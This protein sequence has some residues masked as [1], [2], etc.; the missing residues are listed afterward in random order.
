MKQHIKDNML[1]AVNT[2]QTAGELEQNLNIDVQVERTRDSK[3]GHFAC[4]LAL[5]LAK[6]AKMNPRAIAEKIMAHLPESDLIKHTAIAGPGFINFTLADSAFYDLLKRINAQG[7]D[8]GK[9]TL[10]EG[11]NVHIEYVSANPTGPLHVGHGRGAAYGACVANLLMTCGFKVHR[12]YYVNDAG[13]QMRILALSVYLRYLQLHGQ[14]IELPK[15]AYQGD[16]IIDIAKQVSD[17]FACPTAQHASAQSATMV[18]PQDTNSIVFDSQEILNVLP[19]HLD[20]I[21]DKE[22]LI[23]AYI[24]VVNDKIGADNFEIIRKIALTSILDDIRDDLAEFGVDYEAWFRESHLMTEGSLEAGVNL[25]KEKNYTYEKEGA[26]WFKATELGDEKDRVLIRANGQPTYFASDVAYHLHKYNSGASRIIDVFG[27]DHH[28]YIARIAAFL[29]GLGKDPDKLDVLLVQFAILYRGKEKV[30][31]STRSGSFVTLRELREEVGNDAARYFYIMRR[32]EQ[33][34][35]FDL[36]LAKSKSNENPVYYIQYAHARI[37]SVWRQLEEQQQHWTPDVAT[38]QLDKLQSPHELDLLN[39][40]SRY[41]ETLE[42]AALNYEPH[43]VAYYLQELANA[44]HSY[45]NAEKFLV[46]DKALRD[47]RLFLIH[48]A[49]NVFVNGLAILGVSAPTQM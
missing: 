42:S 12:E 5:M 33:H 34:L 30:Q 46:D 1:K 17:R 20:P 11:Q 25:L 43:Q 10:G 28:G 44:F 2:L 16:Y 6:P 23:D 26:I 22:T 39:R 49:Q 36:E 18:A 47:A 37:C 4:N 32:A 15:N 13:R 48:A 8:F 38:V 31:M 41:E 21:E 27:A 40:L 45:Y 3:H 29:K 7:T 9:N 19:S 35:D 14:S 24:E